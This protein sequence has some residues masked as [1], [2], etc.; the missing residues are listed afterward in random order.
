MPET[1]FSTQRG[2]TPQDTRPFVLHEI[3]QFNWYREALPSHLKAAG[4]K[5]RYEQLSAVAFDLPFYRI[6]QVLIVVGNG[7]HICNAYLVHDGHNPQAPVHKL[8]D[9]S[10][11][12]PSIGFPPERPPRDPLDF[13]RI[14]TTR[15]APFLKDGRYPTDCMRIY[16]FQISFGQDHVK[17]I[18]DNHQDTSL[19]TLEIRFAPDY[20]NGLERSIITLQR[21]KDGSVVFTSPHLE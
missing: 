21:Q 13:A 17:V 15:I 10:I 3:D 9:Y 20:R 18:A 16:D 6:P 11:A 4:D 14:F 12:K 7:L 1:K 19:D 8:F 5:H 2:V